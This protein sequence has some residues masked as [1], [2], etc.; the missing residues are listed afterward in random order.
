MLSYILPSDA[1][2]DATSE[3]RMGLKAYWFV[4]LTISI[5]LF[6]KHDHL[7]KSATLKG[8]LIIIQ[9]LGNLKQRMVMQA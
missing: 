1:N 7:V 3:F 6:V 2:V 4:M 5:M 8:K 9:A